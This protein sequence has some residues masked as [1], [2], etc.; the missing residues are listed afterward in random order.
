MTKKVLS[1]LA[2]LL[3]LAASVAAQAEGFTPGSYTGCAQGF[4]GPVEVT[5]EVSEDAIVSIHVGNHNETL[6]IG[7]RAVDE[8]P[9]QMI[10]AQSADVEDR[11]SVV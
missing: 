11:K 5:V 2:A 4:G 1:I 6:G 10:L 7:S 8:L 3:L 9:Q